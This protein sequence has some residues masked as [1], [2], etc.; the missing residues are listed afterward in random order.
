[1]WSLAVLALSARAQVVEGDRPWIPDAGLAA[2]GGPGALWVNPANIS[3][4]PD[5]RYGAWIARDLGQDPTSLAL[6]AGVGGLGIGVHNVAVPGERSDWTLDYAS[7]VRLP[8]RVSVGFRAAWHLTEADR[9]FVAYDVGLAWRPLPWV[10]VAAVARNVTSPDPST[11]AQSG[12]GVALRPFEQVV[13]LSADYL[14]DFDAASP[15]DHLVGALRVRPTEGLYL[16]ASGDVGLDGEYTVGG[17]LELYF[18]TWGGGASS[19]VEGEDAAVVAFLGTDEPGEALVKTGNKV[20]VLVLDHRPPYEKDTSFLASGDPTWLETLELLRRSEEDRTVRGLALVMRG[21]GLS[22]AQAEELRARIASLQASGKRVTAYLYGSGGTTD[23]YV[24]VAADH[25]VL[26]PSEDL[27]LVGVGTEMMFLRGALDLV[28]VEPQFVR[29]RQYKSAVEQYTHTEPTGPSLEQTEA[30]LDDLSEALIGG[31][32]SGRS[33]DPQAVKALIDGGPYTAKEAL[34]K[35]LVDE[36]AYADQVEDVVSAQ[37]DLD[38]P[39]FRGLSEMPQAHSGWKAAAQIAVVYVDGAI[40]TGSSGG[41]GLFGGGGAGSDT[42]VDALDRAREDDQVK[43]VVL[44]VDSPG[45]SSFASDDVHRAIERIQE[46]GK[47]VVVSFGGVAA[48]G[49][50][51]VACGADAIWAEPTTITG[52]IG[53]YSGKFATERLMTRVGVNTTS[54]ERGRNADIY[55]GTEPWDA[56]QLEKMDHMVGATYDEF[57]RKVSDGRGLTPEQV[58]AV[59]GGHVWTGKRAQELK[60]VDEIGGFQDAVADAR[61]R[62]GL[63]GREVALVSYSWSGMLQET[64]APT[65]M[66]V[67]EAAVRVMMPQLSQMLAPKDPIPTSLKP[68]TDALAP[69]LILAADP[70]AVWMYDPSVLEVDGR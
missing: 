55:S 29:R 21:G 49:G 35:G 42:I 64:L 33:L 44:R 66:R 28:G 38:D 19:R 48:S 9:N 53:V 70:E 22:W 45:G 12:V 68:I 50:Y 67:T 40:V 51:Y 27:S 10:G 11:P 26:H 65:Q 54:L 41:G 17:G 59:A 34:E 3:Y 13:T 57:V 58:D 20:P 43:A 8:E 4:D 37:L 6:A 69:A 30:L 25:V 7:S 62:A 18:G 15:R 60:L 24:A 2:E 46:E 39:D 14:H 56:L 36:I 23:Y 32:A 47:P 61:H 5:P 31:I 16:R 52:S 63:D 1:M